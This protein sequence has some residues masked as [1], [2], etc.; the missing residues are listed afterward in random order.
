MGPAA[1]KLTCSFHPRQ[2]AQVLVVHPQQLA[3]Y[4]RA[5]GACMAAW[6]PS[7]GAFIL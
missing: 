6:A 7:P 1:A 2:E 4:A 3:V 5:A